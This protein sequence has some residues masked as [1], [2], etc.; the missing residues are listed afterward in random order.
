[1]LENCCKS[2]NVTFA[3]VPFHRLTSWYFSN[4]TRLHKHVLCFKQIVETEC[5]GKCGSISML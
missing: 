4:K 2:S 5:E 3:N 1:M